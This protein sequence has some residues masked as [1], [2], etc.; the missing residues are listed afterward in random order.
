MCNK[1]LGEK[2]SDCED[3]FCCGGDL[4]KLGS[5]KTVDPSRRRFEAVASKGR[6]RKKKR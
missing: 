3:R 1:N 6:N 4:F 5:E 2:L